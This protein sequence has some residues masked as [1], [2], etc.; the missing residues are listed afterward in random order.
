MEKEEITTLVLQC[1]T[2]NHQRKGQ[3]SKESEIKHESI[4]YTHRIL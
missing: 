2:I 3:K 1:E 4:V